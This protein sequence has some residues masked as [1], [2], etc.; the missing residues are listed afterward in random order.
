MRQKGLTLRDSNFLNST[1]RSIAKCDKH[2][3]KEKELRRQIYVLGL[4]Y[5]RQYHKA[6]IPADIRHPSLEERQLV[7]S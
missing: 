7:A 5:Y 2:G 4:Y 6:G 1:C 3:V